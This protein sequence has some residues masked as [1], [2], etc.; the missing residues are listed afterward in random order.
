MS[1]YTVPISRIPRGEL[2]NC[3]RQ[4]TI[5]ILC[6]H[7]VLCPPPHCIC[8]MLCDLAATSAMLAEAQ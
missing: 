2:Q 3:G 7:R 8:S 4:M 6:T 1:I 5:Q